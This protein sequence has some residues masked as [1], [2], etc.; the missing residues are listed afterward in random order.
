MWHRVR[1]FDEPCDKLFLENLASK[2]PVLFA[3]YG[4]RLHVGKF[5]EARATHSLELVQPD[6]LWWWIR[7]HKSKRRNRALFRLD[8]GSRPRYDLAVTDPQWLKLLQLMPAGIYP[9]SFF[10]KDKPPG[11]FLTV[12][13]SEPFD[14]FHYKL[15][16][17]VVNL[18]A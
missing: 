7:E 6:D 3:D 10:F 17:G 15:V 18:P 11:T 12:S 13:L 4:D 2:S 16:A 5:A 14:N 8:Y 9:H 1:R